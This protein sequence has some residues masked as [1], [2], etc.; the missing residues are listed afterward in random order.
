MTKSYE[1]IVIG[2]GGIGSAA[3]YWLSRDAGKSVLGLEQFTLGHS[4]GASQDHSRIIRLAYHEPEYVALAPHAYTAWH[5]VEQES[6]IQLVVKT[7]GLVIEKRGVADTAFRGKHNAD[8]LASLRQNKID[9]EVLTPAET[10]KRWPQFKIFDD[11][12]VLF[13]KDSGLVDAGKGN[14]VHVALAR[15]RGA[16]ILENAKVQSVRAIGDSVQVRTADETFIARRAIIAADAWTNQ[17]L[18][19]LGIQLPLT[20]TQEQVTYYATPY[21]REF[22]PDRFPVWIYHGKYSFYGFP[23]YGEVATKMAEHKGGHVV[24]TETRTFEADPVRVQRQRDFL[25]DHISHFWGPE[26]YTKTCLYTLTPD[27][28]FIIDTIPGCKQISIAL[29]SAHAYKFA[30]LIGKILSQLATKGSSEYPIE[31]FDI[32]RRAITTPIGAETRLT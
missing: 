26:L 29:G 32:E 15:A 13:Q 18:L 6:G 9:C 21:L 4:N 3:L 20:V 24:T 5:E 8:Y 17:V 23:V 28:N 11:E 16:T 22:A 19:S 25:A 14:A 30:G 27:E 31:A 12:E 10:I 7:G 1:Y 2:C